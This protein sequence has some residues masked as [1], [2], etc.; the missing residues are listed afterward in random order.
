[1]CSSLM[2]FVCT[3]VLDETQFLF[4]A[5]GGINTDTTSG[6]FSPGLTLLWK[7]LLGG[8]VNRTVM[9]N[10]VAKSFWHSHPA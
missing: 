8:L 2:I 7:Q 5:F 6:Y 10:G 1:M 9:A 4:P 3:Q